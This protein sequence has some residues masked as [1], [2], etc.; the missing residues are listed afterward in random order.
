MIDHRRMSATASGGAGGRGDAP[1]QLAP[2]G[3]R[4]GRGVAR[5]VL[6]EQVKE[7]LLERILR[8]ELAAGDRLVETRIAQELGTSQAPV[9]EAL[10][11]LELLRLVESEPFRGARVRAPSDEDLLDVFPVRAVLEELA[12]REAAKLLDGDVTALQREIDAMRRAAARGDTRAQISRDIAFHRRVVEAARNRMLLQ[13]WAALGIEVPTAFGIY[14]TYFD[15]LEL[16]DF[17]RPIV[18]AIRD[19]DPARAAAEARRHVRRTEKV[20]RRRR[21]R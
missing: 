21:A 5:T 19:R 16:V 6:R 20:V 2:A 4:E 15:A 14:H 3:D 18:E 1:A 9:R 10:R 13:A 8:G 7:I 11:D 17:H 12:A